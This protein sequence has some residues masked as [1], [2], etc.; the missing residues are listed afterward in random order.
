MPS[1][2][3]LLKQGALSS[4]ADDVLCSLSPGHDWDVPALRGPLL[5]NVSFWILILFWRPEHH[6]PC[7]FSVGN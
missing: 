3:P 6:V 2:W 5:Q 4:I 7:Q 1:H